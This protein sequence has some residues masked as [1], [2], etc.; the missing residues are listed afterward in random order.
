MEIKNLDVLVW[1]KQIIRSFS[2]SFDSWKTYTVLGKNWSWK[3][4]IAGVIA[5]NPKYEIAS[6]NIV[7]DWEIINEFDAYERAK[8]WIFLAFQNTPEIPWLNMW[9]YLREIYNSYLETRW[10]LLKKVSPFI[11][12]RHIKKFLDEVW[13][14]ENI[15]SRELNVW[16]SW[17]EKRKIELLQL[18]L[19]D[20]KIII[21]DEIDSWLDFDALKTASENIKK[22]YL[23]DKTLIIITHNFEFIKSF[24]VDSV[25]IMQDWEIKQS[26]WAEIIDEIKE[27]WYNDLLS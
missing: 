18:K 16:F 17:W 12:K 3:S 26:W 8:L 9:E 2:F 5:W 10:W 21:L 27:N 25:L 19:I 13:L 15:L 22:I 1:D 4:S 6:W 20:P 7:L 24:D 11:F 14:P 23:E